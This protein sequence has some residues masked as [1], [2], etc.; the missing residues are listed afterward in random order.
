MGFKKEA[1]GRGGSLPANPTY[2]LSILKSWQPTTTGGFPLLLTVHLFNALHVHVTH[3]T[4]FD[5]SVDF[6]I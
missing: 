3:P 6:A 2:A 5:P 1:G 4:L